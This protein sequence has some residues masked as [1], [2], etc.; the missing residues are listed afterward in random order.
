MI[1]LRKLVIPLTALSRNPFNTEKKHIYLNRNANGQDIARIIKFDSYVPEVSPI[2]H[3]K[4]TNILWHILE[5]LAY[6]T[7]THTHVVSSLNGFL[8]QN[9]VFMTQLKTEELKET[10]TQM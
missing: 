10:P 7:H 3:K 4:K 9:R 8:F 6:Y 1:V 5:K 2:R